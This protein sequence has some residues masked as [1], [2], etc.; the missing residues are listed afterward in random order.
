MTQLLRYRTGCKRS[1]FSTKACKELAAAMLAL[2]RA[3]KRTPHAETSLSDLRFR[4][5]ALEAK[6]LTIF[7]AHADARKS[8]QGLCS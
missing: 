5:A 1:C 8:Q 3:L 7:D 6:V 4:L 2:S